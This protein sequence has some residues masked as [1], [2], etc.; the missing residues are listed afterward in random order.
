MLTDGAL[1]RKVE[2]SKQRRLMLSSQ[3]RRERE[4]SS[5]RHSENGGPSKAGN[6]RRAANLTCGVEFLDNAVTKERIRRVQ[7]V[8]F[9]FGGA[10]KRTWIEGWWIYVTLEYRGPF[11]TLLQNAKRMQ[12]ERER[13][14]REEMKRKEK[15]LLDLQQVHEVC[16]H[17]VMV[18]GWPL[19]CLR[20][21]TTT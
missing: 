7:K 11:L 18:Y 17:T 8:F 2:A 9:G 14:L 3:Q 5:Q 13:L 16:V 20:P 15:R 21:W 12:L 10:G 1:T 4:E 6:A 19:E